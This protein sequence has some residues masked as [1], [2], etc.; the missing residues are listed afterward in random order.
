MI[1]IK[2]DYINN[3]HQGTVLL[4]RLRSNSIMFICAATHCR[5]VHGLVSP[6]LHPLTPFLL[7]LIPRVCWLYGIVYMWYPKGNRLS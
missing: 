7:C 5:G 3:D 1:V 2:S 4:L 6:P